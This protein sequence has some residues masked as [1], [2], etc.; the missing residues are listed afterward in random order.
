MNETL[1]N[2]QVKETLNNINLLLGQLTVSGD[3]VFQLADCRR[4]L[5]QVIN[6]MQVEESESE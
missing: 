1:T 5:T 2:I 3:G 6:Q 4:A